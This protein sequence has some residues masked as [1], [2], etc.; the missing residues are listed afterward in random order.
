MM[1]IMT[2]LNPKN[3]AAVMAFVQLVRKN[4]KLIFTVMDNIA[5][6]TPN[7]VDDAVVEALAQVFGFEL[8]PDK[9][10]AASEKLGEAQG[11]YDAKKEAGEPLEEST[12]L[13][14]EVVDN[15]DAFNDGATVPD[16]E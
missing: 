16:E 4:R 14:T 6:K 12:V 9:V 11:M 8:P 2:T 10:Q 7:Q 13:T 3:I 5:D 1:G 15:L